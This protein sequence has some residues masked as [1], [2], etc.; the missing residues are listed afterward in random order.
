M[1]SPLLILPEIVIVKILSEISLTEL[2]QTVNRT[3]KKLHAI[4]ESNSFLWRDI[5][6]D[7]CVSLTA[8][9]LERILKHSIY[10]ETFD[11][12]FVEIKCQTYEIDFLFSTNLCNCKYL[13]LLNISKSAVST[14][15]FLRHMPL[16]QILNVSECSNLVD[17]DFSVLSTC[18]NL[19]QL[20]VSYTNISSRS[21]INICSKLNLLVLDLSGIRVNV[22][23]LDRVINES[24]LAVY[25]TFAAEVE[26]NDIEVLK[27]NHRDCSIK[28]VKFNYNNYDVAW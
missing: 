22:H 8:N 1:D 24:M 18:K 25:A 26:N 12:P 27:Q 11:I 28:I 23:V 10:F 2:L 3:C 13:Y 15:C 4:I 14:I 19:N 6:P 20:Y 9:D 21:I 5:E 7:F 16:L 17:A